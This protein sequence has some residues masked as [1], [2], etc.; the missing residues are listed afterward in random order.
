MKTWDQRRKRRPLGTV[1]GGHTHK[2]GAERI[3]PDASY[4]LWLPHGRTSLVRWAAS[5]H[6]KYGKKY[7]ENLPKNTQ[8]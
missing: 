3:L 1:F 8:N 2:N 4:P 6:A 5:I 7:N